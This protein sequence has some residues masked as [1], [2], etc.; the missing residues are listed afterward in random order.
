[1][2]DRREQF[3]AIFEFIVARGV[4]QTHHQLQQ[5]QQQQQKVDHSKI[6]TCGALDRK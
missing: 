6:K 2:A 5:Q 4:V 3:R 1:M